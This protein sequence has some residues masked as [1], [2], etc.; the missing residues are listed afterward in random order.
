MSHAPCDA[1][2]VAREEET[3]M[4]QASFFKACTQ[5]RN[6]FRSDVDC[7]LLV[8]LW[9]VLSFMAVV[10]VVYLDYVLFWYAWYPLCILI[11]VAWWYL[12]QAYF[13]IISHVYS[14]KMTS[15]K[16]TDSDKSHSPSSRQPG[17]RISSLF[18]KFNFVLSV[19]LMV[20]GVI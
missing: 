8:Y 1:W 12:R 11:F 20:G 4:M 19:C 13:L 14:N 6:S 3:K 16:N 9:L 2:L 10:A 18:I 17:I 5:R 7:D 15:L